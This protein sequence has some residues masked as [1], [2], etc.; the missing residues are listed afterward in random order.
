MCR[1]VPEI[2][3]ND[4]FNFSAKAHSDKQISRQISTI[5]FSN[6]L[7]EPVRLVRQF[8]FIFFSLRMRQICILEKLNFKI[9]RGS[10]PPDPPSVLAS[11]P[12]DPIVSQTSYELL[13]LGL[14]YEKRVCIFDIRE[15]R[16]NMRYVLIVNSLLW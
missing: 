4:D 13:P 11:S 2:E 8:R 7:M 6:A 14:S 10:M 5:V 15:V 12:F 1:G 9:F 3:M 16:N